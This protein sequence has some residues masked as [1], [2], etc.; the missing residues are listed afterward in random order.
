M[1]EKDIIKLT[2]SQTQLYMYWQGELLAMQNNINGMIRMLLNKIMNDS[3][4]LFASELKVDRSKYAF[5]PQL[6]AF[7]KKEDKKEEKNK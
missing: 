4:A 3:Q 6:L 2:S 1:E 5:N 7:V